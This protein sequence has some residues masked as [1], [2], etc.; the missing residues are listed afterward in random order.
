MQNHTAYALIFAVLMQGVAVVWTVSGLFA[1]VQHNTAR[2]S[3]LS[4]EFREMD[5]SVSELQVQYSHDMA[6][7]DTNLEYIKQAISVI[8]AQK[9]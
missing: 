5:D 2:L 9:D 6:R 3:D 7:I 8:V 1:D 4:S